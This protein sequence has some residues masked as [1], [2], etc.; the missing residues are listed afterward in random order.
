MAAGAPSLVPADADHGVLRRIVDRCEMILSSNV[1]LK[2]SHC[3]FHMKE[4]LLR[5]PHSLLPLRIHLPHKQKSRSF[6][7]LIWQGQKDSNPQQRFWRPTCYH[8]TMP[9][10]IPNIDHYTR[11]LLGCQYAEGIFYT[12]CGARDPSDMAAAGE[13]LTV[14]AFDV[15]STRG[16]GGSWRNGRAAER[17][18]R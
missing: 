9:L 8:Y 15:A 5:Q 11:V 12:G 2:K 14:P 13:T 1:V 4:A 18:S 3:I 7:R 6:D 17:R 10:N 16:R